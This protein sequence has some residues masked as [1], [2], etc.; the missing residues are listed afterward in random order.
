MRG[1]GGNV[2]PDR[3]SKNDAGPFVCVEVGKVACTGRLGIGSRAILKATL[4]RTDMSPQRRGE[5]ARRPRHRGSFE[6]RCSGCGHQVFIG[7][8]ALACLVEHG[9]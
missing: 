5:R 9:T 7:R 6:G 1:D 8:A 4:H 2:C 3:C